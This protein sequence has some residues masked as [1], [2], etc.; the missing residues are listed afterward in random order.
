MNTKKTSRI[1]LAFL[2]LFF[3][4]PPSKA[5]APFVWQKDFESYLENLRQEFHIPGIAIGIIGGDP[6]HEEQLTAITQGYRN[7]QDQQLVTPHTLYGIGSTTKA[8][9]GLLAA[10]LAQEGYQGSKLNLQQPVHDYL[11]NFN[12]KNF[13]TLTAQDLMGHW[14]GFGRHDLA[15]YHRD[16]TQLDFLSL[17]NQLPASEAPRQHFIYNNWMWGVIGKIEEKFYAQPWDVILKKQ[18]LE[19]L[20]MNH[21]LTN[22]N[23]VLQQ[24]DRARPYTTTWTPE[25]YQTEETSYYPLQKAEALKPAGAIYSNLEDLSQWLRLQL[26]QGTLDGVT[27]VQP[28]TLALARQDYS[29]LNRE[30]HYSMGWMHTTLWGMNLYTHDGSIDGFTANISY[31][32]ELKTGV[33]ILM[34]E[35]LMAPENIAIALWQYLHFGKL[36][37]DIP[38]IVAQSVIQSIKDQVLPPNHSDVPPQYPLSHYVGSYCNPLYGK[39]QLST[40]ADANNLTT[41]LF[42]HYLLKLELHSVG[43]V[44]SDPSI[45]VLDNTLSD[46]FEFKEVNNRLLK[47]IFIKTTPGPIQT[48]ELYWYLESTLKEPIVFKSCLN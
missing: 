33:V 22:E 46:E 25:G 35:N 34:N 27:I 45:P 28:E 30:T 9:T 11:E 26:S 19:P 12:P 21:T 41:L 47:S 18:L 29:S 2:T 4:S 31:I 43:P 14:T 44:S 1:I 42:D 23:L 24:D 20:A 40:L 39:I 8:F 6:Q 13:E 37:S 36:V 48:R 7:L 3:Y 16:L 15:W 38:R 5:Q 17:V 32:P 10:K